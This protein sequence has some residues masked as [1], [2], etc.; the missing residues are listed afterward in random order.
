MINPCALYRIAHFIASLISTDTA[1]RLPCEI[2]LYPSNLFL[3]FKNETINFS[4]V[5]WRSFSMKY[6]ETFCGELKSI[7]SIFLW[8]YASLR[9][10]SIAAHI[11]TALSF[12]MP[13]TSIKSRQLR[14]SKKSMPS[15]SFASKKSTT[16]WATSVTALPRVPV[17]MRIDTK[18]TRLTFVDSA[19]R[20]LGRSSGR[21]SLIFIK[22]LH[23]A[24]H[25]R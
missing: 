3:T 15:C 21:I 16:S 1:S 19:K 9:P 13:L 22:T 24:A 20:S 12:P 6:L 5:S 18:S 10:S 8:R 4:C 23:F 17:R 25:G 7:S 14:S 2:T 11:V